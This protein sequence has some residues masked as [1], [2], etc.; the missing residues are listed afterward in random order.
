MQWKTAIQ[1]PQLF[2][3]LLVLGVFGYDNAKGLTQNQAFHN[4][5]PARLNQCQRACHQIVLAMAD[6]IRQIHDMGIAGSRNR[7]GSKNMTGL[8]IDNHIL[9]LRNL[10]NGKIHCRPIHFFQVNRRQKVHPPHQMPA[11]CHRAGQALHAVCHCQLIKQ[12]Q[13]VI[14]LQIIRNVFFFNTFFLIAMI[15]GIIG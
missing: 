6:F 9:F 12:I 2:N 1:R 3:Q 5:C 13:F 14:R 15:P 7:A 10:S 4:R 8:E 11:I